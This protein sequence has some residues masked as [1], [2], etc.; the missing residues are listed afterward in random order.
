M[1]E[2]ELKRII[3]L[4]GNNVFQTAFCYMKS[5]ADAEDIREEAFIKLY[6]SG[7]S[8]DTDE[9]IKAWLLR[10]TANL[11]KDRLRSFWYKKILPLETAADIG[12]EEKPQDEFI[13]YLFMLKPDYRIA[14]YMH[15]YEGYTAREIAKITGGKEN[16][17]LS[18]LSRG[19]KQLKDILLKEGYDESE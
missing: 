19:R 8:F 2:N 15:Y 3:E 14:L 7:K 11:C 9:Y 10:V 17:V 12:T 5:Y 18:H 13:S 6:L 4:F 1:T 16:T